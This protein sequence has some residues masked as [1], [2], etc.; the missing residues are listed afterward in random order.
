MLEQS[1]KIEEFINNGSH[2][3]YKTA[4]AIDAEVAGVNPLQTTSKQFFSFSNFLR[5]TCKTFILCII[6]SLEIQLNEML[7]DRNHSET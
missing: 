7:N 6:T 4:I 3:F 1:N 5:I 2:W